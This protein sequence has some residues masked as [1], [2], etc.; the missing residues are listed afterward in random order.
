M[1][2]LLITNKIQNVILAIQFD[3]CFNTHTIWLFA[4]WNVLHCLVAKWIPALNR[5]LHYK[6]YLYFLYIFIKRAWSTVSRSLTHPDFFI[7]LTGI[8][9]NWSHI[10]ETPLSASVKQKSLWTELWIIFHCFHTKCSQWPHFPKSMNS[11]LIRT[12]PAAKHYVFTSHFSNAIALL[13]FKTEWW[14]IACISA[15]NNVQKNRTSCRIFT[16]KWNQKYFQT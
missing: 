4:A 13:L 16:I 3:H 9:P 5:T 15:E 12:P 10:I 1:G 6:V 7:L 11:F 8:G 2:T 14:Q